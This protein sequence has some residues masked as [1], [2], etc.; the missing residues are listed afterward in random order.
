MSDLT[1][2]PSPSEGTEQRLRAPAI[3]GS[4]AIQFARRI[5]PMALL[6]GIAGGSCVAGPWP[7]WRG[8]IGNGVSPEK[9]AT[10]K[11]SAT[12]NVRWRAPL[13]E[14]GNS[15]PI[16][17]GRRVF[18]TQ[19]IERENRR[20]LMCFDRRNGRLLWQSGVLY[21]EKDTTHESNPHCS[22]S[23]VTDGTRVVAW[24]G[25]GGLHCYDN[26]GRETW[27]RDLGKQTHPFGYG[28]SPI[29]HG[30]LCVLNFG[31]GD[32]S[33]LIAVDKATGRTRWQVKQPLYTLPYDGPTGSFSTPIVTRNGDH[34]ELIVPWPTR[35]FAVDPATGGEL[36]SCSGLD[37]QILASP[38]IGDG[39][40]VSMG[41]FRGRSIATRL[42][43]RGDITPTHKLW[44]NKTTLITTGIIHDQHLY[45]VRMSGTAMCLDLKAG[46]KVWEERLRGASPKNDAWASLV[47]VG[48]RLYV[49]NQSGD[50]CVFRASPKFELLSVNSIGG[51]ECNASLAVSDGQVFQRTH[52]A[53]WCFEERKRP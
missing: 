23:A 29:L 3:S 49:P 28:A 19:A 35:L 46:E 8:P 39:V 13:P 40:A 47:L 11:W 24:F 53:L 21:S 41:G 26:R 43:G 37:P 38:M 25:S 5:L 50:T 4:V 16:V 44:E 1:R 36:W 12:Q 15:S 7:S 22:S 32:P 34:D 51:E 6:L 45:V 14:P 10:E 48:D 27:S 33:Y 17:W 2:N 30:D 20:S 42:G 9:R 52:Q 18:L 31:P